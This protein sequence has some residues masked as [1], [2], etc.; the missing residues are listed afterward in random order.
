[1]NLNETLRANDL[2]DLVKKVVEIDSYKSKIGKDED[3]CV[4]TFTVDQEDVAKDLEKFFEMGYNFILD[5]DCTPGELDDG[6]YRVYVEI[7]RTRHIGNQVFELLEGVMKVT[8]LEEIRF[9]YFKSFK[10]ESATLGNLTAAIPKD[11]E[12]YEIATKKN[13]LDNFSNFFSNSYADT[14]NVVDESISFTRP[15]AGTV[16]F[17]I[18]DSGNKR[19]IYDSIKGPIILESKD[20]AEVM[21]LTKVIGNYNIN[22]IKDIFIFENSNWAVALKRK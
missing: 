15:Y 14:L 20:M 1:M 2:R 9:R 5:A 6:K 18:V 12:A 4:L 22:K 17:D 10:S 3:I 7:E 13:N 21:F 19:D 8:G 16:T 11:K